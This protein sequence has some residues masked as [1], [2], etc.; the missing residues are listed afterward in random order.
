MPLSTGIWCVWVCVFV[1]IWSGMITADV[2]TSLSKILFSTWCCE[3][4]T[5]A[6][7][8]WCTPL[9]VVCPSHVRWL[10]GLW[11]ATETVLGWNYDPFSWS[12]LLY[13]PRKN[14]SNISWN[15]TSLGLL[16]NVLVCLGKKGSWLS[17]SC[18]LEMWKMH[19]VSRWWL[20][21]AQKSREGGNDAQ[22]FS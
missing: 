2:E 5:V 8:F 1:R 19:L 6:C 16:H 22:N 12:Y 17:F 9:F 7:V 21:S 4:G 10:S 11:A 20:K 18:I 3:E 13:N 15:L 14:V